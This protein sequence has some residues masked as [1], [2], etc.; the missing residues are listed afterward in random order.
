MSVSQNLDG[1][2]ASNSEN[3][4][5]CT[6]D[7]RLQADLF[8]P[9]NDFKRAP[10]P[11]KTKL[12]RENKAARMRHAS[13][14]RSGAAELKMPPVNTMSAAKLAISHRVSTR[15]ECIEIH[16]RLIE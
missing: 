14:S 9:T 8:N 13:F 12:G 6:R 1:K 5:F 2:S 11:N 4:W 7:R 3:G 10:I 16:G 15:T